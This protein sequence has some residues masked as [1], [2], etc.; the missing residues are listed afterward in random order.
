MGTK[1]SQN[2]LSASW[3]EPRKQA[4]GVIQFKFDDLRISGAEG[5]SP[6]SSPKVQELDQGA[7]AVSLPASLNAQELRVLMIS[8]LFYW[9]LQLTNETHSHWWGPS[10]LSLPVQMLT[11]FR[12]TLQ[13][14]PEVRP[15]ASWA[16]L[17]PVKLTHKFNHQWWLPV[18]NL[19]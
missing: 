19:S 9:G 13:T 15:V 3:K 7:G 10:L 6:H 17:S 16:S 18:W 1:K 14:H 5:L 2:L 12:D 11:W 4:S 8:F